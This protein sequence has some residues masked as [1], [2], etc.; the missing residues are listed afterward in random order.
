MTQ[1]SKHLIITDASPIQE[2]LLV[3]FMDRRGRELCLSVHDIRRVEKVRS[4]WFTSIPSHIA[5]Q[6][7]LY[8]YY[9]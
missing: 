7:N 1:S 6:R 4:L 3:Y 5:K 9:F 2:G 8:H